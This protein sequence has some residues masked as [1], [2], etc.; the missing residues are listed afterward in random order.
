MRLLGTV[1]ASEMRSNAEYFERGDVLYGRLRPYLNKVFRADFEGLC[2]AEFIP[3]RKVSHLESRYL[4]YFLNS[5]EFVSFATH[6][7]EGDRPRVRLE[8]IADYPFPLPPLPEQQRIVD[9]IEAQFTRLD[10][11]VAAL[12]RA[13]ANLRRYPGSV[14]KTACEGRLVPQN[15]THEPAGQLLERILAERREQWNGRSP[16]TEP[17]PPDITNLRELPVGW[18]WTMVEQLGDVI[19]GLTKNANRKTF[20]LKLPCLRVANVYANKLRLDDVQE[21][22]VLENELERIM[23]KSGGCR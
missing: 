17:T 22:G 18:V 21:I 10:A 5:W 20:P 16:Y 14:L 1:P 4:Q 9:E 19:G 11:V 6:L 15:P 3:F 7:N 13:R 23:L 2:S 8:Q 12:K